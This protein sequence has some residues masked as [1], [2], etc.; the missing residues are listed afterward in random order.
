[1]LIGLGVVALAVVA[2]LFVSE[3]FA[4]RRQRKADQNDSSEPRQLV[5]TSPTD[6]MRSESSSTYK[7]LTESNPIQRF[8]AKHKRIKVAGDTKEIIAADTE[9]M[10]VE[11]DQVKTYLSERNEIQRLQDTGEVLPLEKE[12]TIAELEAE[13]AENKLRAA[14]ARKEHDELHR[15]SPEPSAT[16]IEEDPQDRYLRHLKKR[17]N[18]LGGRA[19]AFRTVE[20]ELAETHKDDPELLATKQDI[21][22]RIYEEDLRK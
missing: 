17:L 14:R 3:R 21:L 10:K 12:K 22:H 9:M 18:E 4:S 7:H 8:R 15:P 20:N 19:E 11:A 1:M 6:L 5:H 16:Q 13:I 2:L